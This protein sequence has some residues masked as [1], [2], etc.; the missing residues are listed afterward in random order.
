MHLTEP[1]RSCIDDII[2]T[3]GSGIKAMVLDEFTTGVVGIAFS[4]SEMLLREVYLFEYIDSIFESTERINNL[5]CIVILRPTKDN[6]EA[7]SRELAHPHYR[8]Y[9]IYFTGRIGSLLV[10]KLAEAD[11]REVVRAINEL[12]LDFL[13]VNPFIFQLRLRNKTFDLKTNDWVPEGLRRTCD[14]LSSLLIALRIN[15]IIRFQTQSE[16]CKSLAEKVSSVLRC[17]YI[18]NKEWKETAP[19]DTSSLLL[20]VDRRYDLVSPII[21]SWYYCSMIYNEFTVVNN[22]VNLEDV[23]NRQA[24]DPKEMILSIENDHFYGENFYKNFGEIGPTLLSAVECLKAQTKSQHKVE[25]L[26][27]MKRFIDEYPETKR[28][29]ND[30]HNHVFLMS[31]IGRIVNDYS[32]MSVSECEQE[33]SCDL[34]SH[35]EVVK[36]IGQLICSSKI[37]PEDAIR[38]VCLYTVYHDDKSNLNG[39]LK[40]LKTRVDI[41]PD[42]VEFV[43]QLRE[44][45]LS[46]PQNPLDVTVQRVAKKIV[47]GVKGVEN[48]LTQY[49]PSLAEILGDLRRGKL[50]EADFAF[51]GQRCREELPK[52][53][54]VYIVGGITLDEAL[55]VDQLNRS[56]PYECQTIIG[57]DT[58]HNFRSFRD[59]IQHS[60]TRL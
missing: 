37:R 52:R 24:K 1:V 53:I 29:A 25:S 47:Q 27:D 15:P 39:L 43:N 41:T 21:H 30:L 17:E 20:I 42:D 5:K 46:K 34:V 6:V 40:L 10:K 50:K 59:E 45:R 19:H 12:P 26:A 56:S 38:L 33:L 7:L 28:Y 36:K 57:G 9:H 51:S 16:L 23:P 2:R 18:S 32:L 31:D 3:T 13:P 58:V 35:S 54:I 44:F 60:V 14:G 11:E 8:T 4:R 55:V 22:R 48:V 49:C